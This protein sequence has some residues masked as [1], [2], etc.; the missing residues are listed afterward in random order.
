MKWLVLILLLLI[1]CDVLNVNCDS[2]FGHEGHNTVTD[3]DPE[4]NY[5]SIIYGEWSNNDSLNP[6]T[7][8]FNYGEGTKSFFDSTYQIK[9]SATIDEIVYEI[10]STIDTLKYSMINDSLMKIEMNITTDTLMRIFK[11]NPI[12]INEWVTDSVGDTLGFGIGDTLEFLKKV[13]FHLFNNIEY[14]VNM[15]TEHSNDTLLHYFSCTNSRILIKEFNLKIEEVRSI[16]LIY[17]IDDDS[18]L[19]LAK[20]TDQYKVYKKVN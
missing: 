1:G 8:F 16:D 13:N 5:N 2:G 12:I 19:R 11:G 17:I 10:D 20:D 4:P 6:I 14:K 7:F 3:E 9:Y 15:Y 18:T